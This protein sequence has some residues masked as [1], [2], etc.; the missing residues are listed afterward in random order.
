MSSDLT[1]TEIVEE[2]QSSRFSFPKWREALFLSSVGGMSFLFGFGSAV[3][4]AKKKDADAFD[5]GVTP[6]LKSESGVALASRALR[7]GTFYAFTGCGILFFTIWKLMGVKNL[8]EF[9]QKSGEMLPRIPKNDPP[10]SRTEFKSLTDLLQ[11]VIDEDEKNKAASTNSNN[12]D[13]TNRIEAK[14]SNSIN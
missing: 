9:R 6:S 2:E 14:D 1:T 5:K 7:W 11:Y 3:S 13:N 4:T 8:Q 10:Q 12:H